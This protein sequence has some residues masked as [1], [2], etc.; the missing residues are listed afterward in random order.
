MNYEPFFLLAKMYADKKITHDGFV[1]R[2]ALTQKP[3]NDEEAFRRRLGLARQYGENIIPFPWQ[4]ERQA[5]CN[6]TVRALA[7]AHE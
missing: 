6:K 3:Y 5:R 2:W 1:A 7:R 4:D